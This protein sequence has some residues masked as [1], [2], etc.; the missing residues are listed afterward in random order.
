MGVGATPEVV[1]SP[2]LVRPVRE[3]LEHDRVIR[4]LQARYK[5]KYEVGIN[6]GPSLTAPV[7]P[8]MAAV[9]PDVV[10]QAPDRGRKLLG[11][12]EVETGESVNHLE[13][14]SQWAA[15]ARLKVPFLLYVPAGSVDTARRLCSDYHITAAEIWTYH[16]VGDEIRFTLIQKNA[17]VPIPREAPPA[18]AP[19]KAAVKAP[20]T[21]PAKAPVKL[22]STARP[23]PKSAKAGSGPVKPVKAVAKSVGKAAAKAVSKAPAKPSKPLKPAARTTKVVKPA[24]TAKAST[25]VKSARKAAIKPVPKA[26]AKAK[27]AKGLAKAAKGAKPAPRK[28][29]P[30]ARRSAKSR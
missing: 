25:T 10:L 18:P 12:V 16:T 3:Q 2:I 23:M 26:V 27:V 14:M 13:A 8:A 17:T 7:G 1:L 28:P 5:K 20:A 30:P 22:V 6:P 21:T 9:Y 11:V 19:V 29:V 4:L 15:F 24:R